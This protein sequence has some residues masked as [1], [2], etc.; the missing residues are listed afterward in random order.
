LN[1]NNSRDNI[2]TTTIEVDYKLEKKLERSFIV[3]T[4][5]K[6]LK[7]LIARAKRFA[8]ITTT[9]QEF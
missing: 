1:S 2:T 6:E 5:Y 3:I 8:N 9:I 4:Y 7:E